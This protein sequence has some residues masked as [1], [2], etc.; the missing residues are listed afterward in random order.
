MKD[1]VQVKGLAPL[2]FCK[3]GDR[4]IRPLGNDPC[5]L[6]FCNAFVNEAEILVF[7]LLFLFR[8]FLL[9]LRQLAVLQL[10]RLI[11]IILLLC[12]LDLT[13]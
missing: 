1:L 13:V 3:L 12:I 9:Q 5:D 8:Q 4:Y 11:Q 7:H 2:A 6:V 10:R